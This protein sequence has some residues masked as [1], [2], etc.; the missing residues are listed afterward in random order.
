MDFKTCFLSAI[1]LVSSIMPDNGVIVCPE[2][3][4]RR[5]LPTLDY[6]FI[7]NTHTNFTW[8]DQL[9]PPEDGATI[10][11]NVTSDCPVQWNTTA[12]GVP[13]AP[14]NAVTDAGE[15]VALVHENVNFGGDWL[16]YTVWVNDTAEPCFPRITEVRIQYFDTELPCECPLDPYQKPDVLGAC[17]PNICNH[18]G[19]F[20]YLESNYPCVC[21]D[22]QF[23]QCGVCQG[24]GNTCLGL[25][26]DRAPP[27]FPLAFPYANWDAYW[28]CPNEFVG[29][30]E[31]G[32]EFSIRS[33]L[34]ELAFDAPPPV[35][36]VLGEFTCDFSHNGSS[37]RVNFTDD[38][39][40]L[41]GPVFCGTDSD[42]FG[43]HGDTYE[44]FIFPHVFHFNMSYSAGV[45][46]LPS[47]GLVVVNETAVGPG[48]YSDVN[49][50][51]LQSLIDP[52]LKTRFCGVANGDG[53]QLVLTNSSANT[54]N[55]PNNLAL[56]WLFNL[57]CLPG[58][59]PY[60]GLHE[61]L[62]DGYGSQD[63]DFQWCTPSDLFFVLES[64]C[65]PGPTQSASAS[66]SPSISASMSGSETESP[67]ASESRSL[68]RSAS[69]SASPSHSGSASI[70]QSRS[71]SSSASISSS[72]SETNCCWLNASLPSPNPANCGGTLFPVT[73]N[74]VCAECMCGSDMLPGPFW[75]T[76]CCN[77]TLPFMGE[78]CA[79]VANITQGMCLDECC[80]PTTMMQCMPQNP[81]LEPCNIFDC[82]CDPFQ[83]PMIMPPFQY[84][85]TERYCGPIIEPCMDCVLANRPDCDV[86]F[87]YKGNNSIIMDPQLIMDCQAVHGDICAFP[88]CNLG[89]QPPQM[90]PATQS[91]TI[92][93]SP[94]QSCPPPDYP[95]NLCPPHG[96]RQ[97]FDQ[98]FHPETYDCVCQS[99]HWG[100]CKLCGD[101]DESC[102]CPCE[103]TAAFCDPQ[104]L[105]DGLECLNGMAYTCDP[106]QTP[107][108]L[109]EYTSYG[110]RN[111]WGWYFNDTFAG[112]RGK[113][114]P[115]YG[116]VFGDN[117]ISL[118]HR[119]GRGLRMELFDQQIVFSGHGFGGGKRNNQ[120]LWAGWV[121]LP[122][123][124][125]PREQPYMITAR[126]D[127]GVSED[128]RRVYGTPNQVSLDHCFYVMPT[129]Y[130][131]DNITLCLVADDEGVLFRLE[132]NYRGEDLVDGAISGWGTLYNIACD[133]PCA[134]EVIPNR[135][136]C[137][138]AGIKFVI[139]AA[140]DMRESPSPSP[141]P[142]EECCMRMV[143][144]DIDGAGV[145]QSQSDQFRRRHADERRG[146]AQTES[147]SA[148]GS[149]SFSD[150][151]AEF[152]ICDPTMNPL[153]TEPG[154]DYQF[155]DHFFEDQGLIL[156][157]GDISENFHRE[158]MFFGSLF[159]TFTD[160]GTLLKMVYKPGEG[161]ILIHGHAWG[162]IIDKDGNVIY[163]E[164]H[165]LG[166]Q[167]YHL[168]ILYEDPLI[169]G[170]YPNDIKHVHGLKRTPYGP[171]GVSTI[172]RERNE[173]TTKPLPPGPSTRNFGSLHPKDDPGARID[174]AALSLDYADLFFT[175]AIPEIAPAE[176]L[177]ASIP[178]LT[179]AQAWQAIAA[180]VQ[181]CTGVPPPSPNITDPALL[182]RAEACDPQIQSVPELGLFTAVIEG[183]CPC[184]A[185]ASPTPGCDADSHI[186]PEESQSYT[187]AGETL[188]RSQSSAQSQS[189]SQSFC[190]EPPNMEGG[191][192]RESTFPPEYQDDPRISY[193]G[194]PTRYFVQGNP[195]V[196]ELYD[197]ILDYMAR[198]NSDEIGGGT[199]CMHT[200]V[201]SIPSREYLSLK[202]WIETNVTDDGSVIDPQPPLSPN[203]V[204]LAGCGTADRVKC[205]SPVVANVTPPEPPHFET[206][207][208]IECPANVLD[209]YICVSHQGGIAMPY[210]YFVSGAQWISFEA[211]ECT[212]PYGRIFGQFIADPLERSESPGFGTDNW[213][214]LMSA[215]NLGGFAAVAVVG[216]A[217]FF[218]YRANARVNRRIA[219]LE[220]QL[221]AAP[222]ADAGYRET[223]A[224]GLRTA[225]PVL[226]IVRQG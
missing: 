58:G 62:F 27:E 36:L 70:T 20:D 100:P 66:P 139:E 51:Y 3:I 193:I 93:P 190:G 21:G 187:F 76:S 83:Y 61:D 124:P 183:A 175:D 85:Q 69:P 149:Q 71:M 189:P 86:W 110:L 148:T 5:G 43:G 115:G 167:L 104:N 195:F 7:N 186:S 42:A 157:P 81:P 171:G 131:Q 197:D 185:P 199:V 52:N 34:A 213:T 214:T 41:S 45:T 50:G 17:T 144:V 129:T 57:D 105:P 220:R 164:G 146:I 87:E 78:D 103:R 2:V 15:Y 89:N 113:A 116:I 106:Y 67:S 6:I 210:D 37:V 202:L 201:P 49:C 16:H 75:G 142:K 211:D 13:S 63:I 166:P 225:P 46:Y 98:V 91:A 176:L 127:T 48:N 96:T 44:D 112:D 11:V 130:W 170:E 10:I 154:Y 53:L 101:Q 65:L 174:F 31:A 198:F 196:D 152:L 47:Q 217:G 145:T 99:G 73:M 18:T 156:P 24:D 60:C 141:T 117:S 30:P 125:P 162:R 191:V 140:C 209:L 179:D 95:P 169:G 4:T 163:G 158:G 177:I 92:S 200:A 84:P 122:G 219:D 226:R 14:P 133:D 12:E 204:A 55:E 222:R 56:G 218:S 121:A 136:R 28:R 74:E 77:N 216:F 181:N 153:M 178:G 72:Q 90:C 221:A 54:Y 182:L 180:F 114:E 208:R 212:S 173:T 29:L 184:D 119:D 168:E 137:G 79:S 151:P 59:C 35:G 194:I 8:V 25:C 82:C 203:F 40:V 108:S 188:S 147:Q 134:E 150:L 143:E 22:A 80:A 155:R 23:D 107:L 68:S 9:N 109:E 39:I 138:P 172:V 94:S 88:C 120:D 97:E 1:C 165:P 32:Q 19:V 64:E 207:C 38:A 102:L 126:F 215:G 111:H 123:M 161:Y 206:E 33:V 132:E 224:P 223:D 26:C 118:S 160:P 135:Y 205:G 159:L 192:V 128:Y